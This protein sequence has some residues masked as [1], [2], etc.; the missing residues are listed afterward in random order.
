[1]IRDHLYEPIET[2]NISMTIDYKPTTIIPSIP[3]NTESFTDSYWMGYLNDSNLSSINSIGEIVIAEGNEEDVVWFKP[4]AVKDYRN[5]T[6]FGFY[7]A[8]DSSSGQSATNAFYQYNAQGTSKWEP[9]ASNSYRNLARLVNEMDYQGF[10]YCWVVL[11]F[12][13][14]KTPTS[15]SDFTFNT[16]SSY[17]SA[18][19]ASSTTAQNSLGV[20][21]TIKE[22]R[23]F[24]KG[25]FSFKITNYTL[26]EEQTISIDRFDQN[27]F[28]WIKR[29]EAEPTAEPPIPRDYECLFIHNFTFTENL[30]TEIDINSWRTPTS[31]E[32]QRIFI[33]PAYEQFYQGL[34]DNSETQELVANRSSFWNAYMGL[35]NFRTINTTDY[36]IG[37]FSVVDGSKWVSNVKPANGTTNEIYNVPI[38]LNGASGMFSIT[39]FND[40]ALSSFPK[41]NGNVIIGRSSGSATDQ[42]LMV[43]LSPTEIYKLAT[44]MRWVCVSES[45]AL[46]NATFNAKG[47]KKDVVYYPLVDLETNEFL[48]DLITG[49]EAQI[50]SKLPDWMKNGLENANYDSKDKPSKSDE[51][52]KKPLKP[53]VDPEDYGQSIN[54]NTNNP[55]FSHTSLSTQYNVM[56]GDGVK[57]FFDKLWASPSTFW[58]AMSRN[59]QSDANAFRYLVNLKG[60][61][62]DLPVSSDTSNT[63]YLG[64]GAAV[65]LSTNNF[66]DLTT[67]ITRYGFG[68]LAFS[69]ERQP[70]DFLKMSPY[71]RVIVHLPFIGDCEINPKFILREQSTIYLD[72]IL[73]IRTGDLTYLLY[74]APINDPA[75]TTPI[76]MRQTNIG[77]DIPITGDDIVAH[78]SQIINANLQ[79]VKGTMS[80][81]DSTIQDVGSNLKKLSGSN[82]TKKAMAISTIASDAV[83]GISDFIGN[84]ANKAQASREI[85]MMSGGTTGLSGLYVDSYAYIIIQTPLYQIPKNFGHTHGWMLN[86]RHTISRLNGFT[87]CGNVDLSSITATVEELAEIEDLL[88]SGFF[89]G[90]GGSNSN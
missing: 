2:S 89:A 30:F 85:P 35:L 39:Q 13:H 21:M 43:A 34:D 82:D 59:K 18:L 55:L 68:G 66:K 87:K 42:V 22:F 58:E 32:Y 57:E 24:L 48:G 14:A 50:A 7:N 74:R 5:F 36:K 52:G 79:L 15:T 8:K 41:Y 23:E 64:A 90:N 47:Y 37:N 71:T 54:Y 84:C 12:C 20:Y 45:V 40:S 6:Y 62:C 78:S 72:A 67:L 56:T 46:G 81:I 88:T 28:I 63:I 10:S 77:F 60:Y 80:S 83:A 4:S 70:L 65:E 17:L 1:M 86:E 61:P 9:S 75:Q 29:Q 26:A 38:A 16:S 27:G 69:G 3:I 31:N 25:D 11:Q 73:D 33:E 19:R 53:N 76:L 51:S 44:T 49:S